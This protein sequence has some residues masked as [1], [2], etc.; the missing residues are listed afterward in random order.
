LKKIILLGLITCLLSVAKAQTAYNYQKFGIGLDLSYQRG[1]TN[2]T[3]Q[4]SHIGE[5]INFIYNY[6]PYIPIVAEFQFGT[7]SGGGLTPNLDPFGRE[8]TNNYKAFLLHADF[9]LG[10]V[11]DYSQ[12]DVLNMLKNF[13]FGTGAG[14]LFNDNRVQR[15]NIYPWNG[16][17]TYIFPG[18]DNSVN[19]DIPLRFGYELKIYDDYDEPYMAIDIFYVHSY[20]PGSGLD[21]YNDPNPPFKHNSTDQY[22]QISIG[23]K[24]NFGSITSFTKPITRF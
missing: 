18:K 16:S 21:G 19:V 23:V 1:Y 9:H 24:Y 17:L 5:N 7:L 14:L 12:S 10:E 8:Y 15:T 4:D 22:R 6:S 11:I 3:R 20:V 2:I 13:Y